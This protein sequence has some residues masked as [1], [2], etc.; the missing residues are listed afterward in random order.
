MQ[1]EHMAFVVIMR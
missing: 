1:L